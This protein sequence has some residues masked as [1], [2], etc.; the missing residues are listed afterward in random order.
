MTASQHGG[1]PNIHATLG[2]AV[3]T[4]PE[5]LRCNDVNPK[6]KKQGVYRRRVAG[7]P[8]SAGATTMEGDRMSA[9]DLAAKK[10]LLPFID[11][12]A[13]IEIA[14]AEVNRFTSTYLS[15]S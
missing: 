6:N 9:S 3:D 1:L 5:K 4:P 11:K 7:T 2:P 14:L 10:M 12:L 8:G 13:F 15:A